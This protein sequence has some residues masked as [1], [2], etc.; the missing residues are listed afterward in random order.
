MDSSSEATFTLDPTI[1]V[2]NVPPAVTTRVFGKQAPINPHAQ[3]LLVAASKP[4]ETPKAKATAKSKA[5][6]K[7]S[8]D[9]DKAAKPKVEAAGKSKSKPKTSKSGDKTPKTAR[10]KTPYALAKESYIEMFLDRTDHSI[11]WTVRIGQ[12]MFERVSAMSCRLY[13]T[14]NVCYWLHEIQNI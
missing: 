1:A 5:K 7:A 10:E 9:K 8:K 2:A 11:A 13:K 3:R 12:N 14:E 4:A 6:A